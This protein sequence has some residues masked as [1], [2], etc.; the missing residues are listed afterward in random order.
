MEIYADL[1]FTLCEKLIIILQIRLKCF[2]H[3]KVLSMLCTTW[4]SLK[5]ADHL[6]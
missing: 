2:I 3:F 1:A 5:N 6:L 4:V